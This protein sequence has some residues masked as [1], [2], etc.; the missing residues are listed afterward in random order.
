MG[1][2]VIIAKFT[3]L[4]EMEGVPQLQSA[5]IPGERDDEAD[6]KDRSG[7]EAAA[8]SRRVLPKPS[9]IATCKVTALRFLL[10]RRRKTIFPYGGGE[11]K[12]SGL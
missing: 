5:G 11:A 1:R 9:R 4:R 7:S 8:V 12:T 6:A 3:A 10:R 2:A